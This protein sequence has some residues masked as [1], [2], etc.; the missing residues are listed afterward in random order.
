MHDL[1][2]EFFLS[3]DAFQVNVG[4]LEPILQELERKPHAIV[5]PFVDG[6]DMN[7]MEYSA[8]DSLHRGGFTWDLR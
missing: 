4:W 7:T 6:I 2:R 1:D 5:Q 3:N 8:P